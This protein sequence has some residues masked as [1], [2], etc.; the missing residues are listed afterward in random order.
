MSGTRFEEEAELET[1]NGLF[2]PEIVFFLRYTFKV[3]LQKF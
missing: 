2:S 3:Q 1:G